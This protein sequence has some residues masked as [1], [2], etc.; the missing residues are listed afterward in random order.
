MLKSYWFHKCILL[1]CL[2]GSYD[3]GPSISEIALEVARN[4]VRK[5]TSSPKISE[6]IFEYARKLT[7]PKTLDVIAWFLKKLM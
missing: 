5:V 3:I 1:N 2:A 7:H 4:Q 6:N